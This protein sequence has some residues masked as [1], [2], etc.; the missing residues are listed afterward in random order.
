MGGPF[1]GVIG[2]FD[3]AVIVRRHCGLEANSRSHLGRFPE[4]W[5]FAFGRMID[6]NPDV[7][8]QCQNRIYQLIVSGKGVNR[9]TGH[10][11][12]NVTGFDDVA[13]VLGIRCAN[14]IFRKGSGRLGENGV[15]MHGTEL[16]ILLRGDRLHLRAGNA[17][18]F[19]VVAA[20]SRT[21][22]AAIGKS[23]MNA[24]ERFRTSVI[25][26]VVRK[27]HEVGG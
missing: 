10:I 5:K 25:A 22:K 27:E 1:F 21:Y 23:R 12:P 11:N 26:M 4:E 13:Q 8:P 16:D 2:S 6:Q 9:I 3:K 7:R 18:R 19:K 24:R 15:N 17:F 20:R 14:V